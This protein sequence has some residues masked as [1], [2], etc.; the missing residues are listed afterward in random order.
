MQGDVDYAGFANG[1]V[2]ALRTENGEPIWEHRVMLPEGRSELERMVDVD[3]PPLIEDGALFIGAY[4]GRV[5]G[6]ALRDGRPQWEHEL[7][8][9]LD[10]AHGYGLIYAIDDQDIITAMDQ[11]TGEVAWTQDAFRLRKLSPPLA[12]SNYLLFGD[13]DGY[14]HVL[15]QR[16]G[17]LMGRRKLDGD[18]IRSSIALADSTIYVLGNS[19][20]LHALEVEPK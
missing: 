13:E 10:L 11:N 19:G 20:A 2:L 17:R 18:G 16:D 7:S 5:K 9:Y 8:T 3:M 15:A 1:K 4:H 6:L 12:F 14:L